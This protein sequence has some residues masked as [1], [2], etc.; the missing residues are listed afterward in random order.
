MR[1]F[2]VIA[3]LGLGLLL[4]AGAL[5]GIGP[6]KNVAASVGPASTLAG[7][8]R[9]R[10]SV[11]LAGPFDPLY[12]GEMVAAASGLFEQEDLQVELRPAGSG[13]DPIR[14]VADGIDAIGVTGGERFLLARA[15]GAPI[16]AFAAGYLRS[17]VV[18]YSMSD[19]GIR[20]PAQF[21]DKRVGY[22]SGW[23]TAITYEAMMTR[24][25]IA[26]S[27]VR[28]V[29]VGTDPA[30]FLARE[31]DVWPGYIGVESLLL[32]ERGMRYNIIQPGE[33]GIHWP[34]TVY[35]ANE[36]MLQKNSNVFLRFLRAVIGGWERVYANYDAS[37]QA[38]V[39]FDE[40]SLKL[41]GV[42]LKLEQQREF[43]RPLGARV[44]EFD[45]TQWRSLQDMLQ[46][47]KLLDDRMVISKAVSFDLI[48]EV[49]RQR[50][51]TAG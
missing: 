37:V 4:F 38:I 25:S 33:H 24:M 19:S 48:R 30:P 35:F 16:V 8:Q 2:L 22:Q 36:Q 12:A 46:L 47:Q 41:D 42:R 23:D 32:R 31:V 28:E 15:K 29:S 26:R 1:G 27:R 45:A 11:R 10:L 20:T 5:V 34:G 6:G 18:F 21:I 43:V 7:T 17:R 9:A 14:S 49:Y 39:A 3:T 44:G 50:R 51:A 13:D 40:A